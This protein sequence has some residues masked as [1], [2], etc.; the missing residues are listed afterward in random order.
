[1]SVHE[2][3]NQIRRI[4]EKLPPGGEPP[5]MDPMLERIQ[6]LEKIAERTEDRLR[7]IETD[8]AVVKSNYATKADV[9]DAK[10]AIIMWV[11]GAVFLAQLIPTIPVLLRAFHLLPS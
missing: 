4:E 8:L 6:K 5:T 2:F 9:S 11:V 1:M 10:G 7:A 3:T